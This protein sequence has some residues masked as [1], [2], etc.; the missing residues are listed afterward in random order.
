MSISATWQASNI[1]AIP[2]QLE[3]RSEAWD[4]AMISFLLQ[5]TMGKIELSLGAKN[6]FF[7][8]ITRLILNGST[9]EPPGRYSNHLW[10]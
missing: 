1:Q 5:S 8:Q 6:I 4:N 9:E 7:W 10:L 3:G 2:D